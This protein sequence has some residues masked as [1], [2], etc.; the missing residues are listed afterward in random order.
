MST[1]PPSSLPL[2]RRRLLG[3]AA[4]LAGSGA[5]SGCAA[6]LLR[7]QPPHSVTSDAAFLADLGQRTFR[8]FWETTDARTGLAPDRWPTP[9]FASIAATG[10]ALSAYPV[11]VARGWVSRAQARQRTLTTL[12]FLHDLPQGPQAR[13]VAGQHGF[14]YHFLDMADGLRFAQCELST[15]DTAL[16]MAGVLH[17]QSFFDGQH[18]DEVS[19]RALAQALYDGV[20]WTW[21]QARGAAISHGWLPES[22][23]LAYD[24]KGYNEALLLYVL[25]LGSSTHAVGADAWQAWTS[26]YSSQSWGGAPGQEH[27]QFAPLFGHQFSHCWIDFRGLQDSYLSP[28][29]LDYFENSRRATLAQ[30]A[31]AVANPMGWQ[32][33]G[34]RVW[35]ISASDGPAD[36]RRE[37]A[38][39][40]RQFHSYA[41]RGMGAAHYDDGTIAPY[42]AGSSIVF[43]PELV[44]PT[45]RHLR[46]RYGA[47]I[48]NQYGFL[49][50][51]N[52]SFYFA[53]VPLQHGRLTQIGWVDGDQL[54][55][56]QGPLLAMLANHHDEGIWQVMRRHPVLRRGLQRAGFHGGWLVQAG[57]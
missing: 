14:F 16:L 30:Q 17:A 24:W 47:H 21:A 29:G 57:A 25:A 32:D 51:F 22:G 6:E 12:S 54:G 34:A 39:R 42:A 28:R 2:T 7:E 44:I 3:L 56:D 33:Y 26:T 52:P 41:G 1:L 46:D 18:P 48:W 19:I 20:D 4:A 43:A 5:V 23:F 9:S 36:V 15:I 8:Y 37:V 31:Y 13:G 10:F 11:G 45:L 50:A 35:G 27:L 38:G 49:D 53:D 55:I 40:T